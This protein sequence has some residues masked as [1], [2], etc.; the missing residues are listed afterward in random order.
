MEPSGFPPVD[1]NQSR[2]RGWINPIQPNTTST[3]AEMNAMPK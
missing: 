1:V 3:Q 2:P